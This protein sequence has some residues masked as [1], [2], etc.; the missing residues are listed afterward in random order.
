MFKKIA[1]LSML[2]MG[3]VLFSQ[4]IKG[5]PFFKE[6]TH[7]QAFCEDN[8]QEATESTLQYLEAFC[9]KLMIDFPNLHLNV[10]QDSEK[11]KL[12]VFP[13]I[14]SHHNARDEKWHH[15]SD[16][17][18][19][20]FVAD[21]N[22]LQMASINNPG[23]VH[24]KESAINSCKTILAWELLFSNNKFHPSWLALGLGLFEARA[25][26]RDLIIE[27]LVNDG[28]FEILP[29]S[30][31]EPELTENPDR[32]IFI[33]YYVLVEYL[34]DHW[35]WDKALALLD[36]YSEFE[37]ILGISKED[38]RKECIQYYQSHIEGKV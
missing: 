10:T 2:L 27:Y 1:L 36:N 15:N 9:E 3:N 22:V 35:G 25:Y 5:L 26:S 7:F 21:E 37:S 19:A 13:D 14:K 29:L 16:W 34:V 23:P 31:L 18:V 11:I 24:T 28:K 32:S 30:Q 8:D 4:E 17:A 12:L 20:G 38:F 33:S 6:T